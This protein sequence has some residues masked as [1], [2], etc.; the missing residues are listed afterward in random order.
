MRALSRRRG[1]TLHRLKHASKPHLIQLYNQLAKHRY[2]GL[3]LALHTLLLRWLWVPNAASSACS[4][5]LPRISV[6]NHPAAPHHARTYFGR[7]YLQLRDTPLPPPSHHQI[8]DQEAESRTPR[9]ETIAS[10][11]DMGS[12]HNTINSN[13]PSH[14]VSSLSCRALYSLT[15]KEIQMLHPRQSIVAAQD[16][17]VCARYQVHTQSRHYNIDLQEAQ[18]LRRKKFLAHCLK[19]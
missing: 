15:R 10:E 13:S 6:N 4:P 16:H 14:T 11:T 8:G 19:S 12:H 2:D 17:S 3:A 5:S 1:T 9:K 7:M 18:D